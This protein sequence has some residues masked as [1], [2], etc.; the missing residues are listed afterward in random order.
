MTKRKKTKSKRSELSSSSHS[1]TVTVEYQCLELRPGA[2][3]EGV[4]AVRGS[5]S[6]RREESR[7][8]ERLGDLLPLRRG[9][10]ER[11][12]GTPSAIEGAAE[13]S[14]WRR[15]RGG[16]ATG[17]RGSGSSAHPEGSSFLLGL[18]EKKGRSKKVRASVFFLRKQNKKR[19]R[20]LLLLLPR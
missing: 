9:P 15:R 10:P 11:L 16:G 4:G 18:R 20:D 12:G 3:D 19:W 14:E 1:L 17:D 13:G 7:L 8:K 2:G 6:E 5:R